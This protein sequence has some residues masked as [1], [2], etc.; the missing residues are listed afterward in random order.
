MELVRFCFTI[1]MQQIL[2]GFNTFLQREELKTTSYI[3]ISYSDMLLEYEKAA[4]K[5]NGDYY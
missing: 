1:P 3:Q 5:K 2:I 4:F